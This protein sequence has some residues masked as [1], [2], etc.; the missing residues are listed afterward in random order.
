MQN[1][2]EDSR[3][4]R[5][6]SLPS[7][8]ISRRLQTVVFRGLLRPKGSVGFHLSGDERL[9]DDWYNAFLKVKDMYKD[10][11]SNHD[12]TH[13]SLFE[14]LTFSLLLSLL[15]TSLTSIIIENGQTTQQTSNQTE[16]KQENSP[17]SSRYTTSFYPI[18]GC[19][20][21]TQRRDE[22]HLPAS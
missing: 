4:Q 6:E 10:Y 15:T 21:S 22:F 14:P 2:G 5:N 19:A 20:D 7:R 1:P 3:L 8:A 9:R 13:P 17:S 11:G 18:H 16:S 12:Y